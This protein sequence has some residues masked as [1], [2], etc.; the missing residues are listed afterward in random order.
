MH[1]NRA[2]FSTIIAMLMTAFLTILA[3][4]ILNLFL[5]ENRINHFLSDGIATY[6]GAEGSLE[7]A[8]LK[9]GNH[10]EG[11]SDAITPADAES[12]ILGIGN[13]LSNSY[14]MQTS[15]KSY[16][17]TLANG[18]FEIIPLF[19]DNGTPI[20]VNTKNPNAGTSN[21]IKSSGFLVRT[22]GDLVWNIIGNDTT[23]ASFG[24][25]GTGSVTLSF[26]DNASAAT[27]AG[28]EKYG[29]S[30]RLK[31]RLVTIADFLANH[32]NNYLVLYSVSDT[33]VSYSIESPIGFS[34]PIRSVIASSTLGTSKQNIEFSENRS[35]LFDMLKY[36]LFSK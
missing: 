2:G 16:S 29:E 26:G 24:I 32:E 5:T 7:Y 36:S 23:G 15:G 33:P 27:K 22:D 11:F 19:Y 10:R 35:K 8:L 13:K 21:V 18:A 34:F 1:S 30:D 25:V 6:M 31:A 28:L 9:I 17:G 3:A 4:G 14:T 20:G 12:N